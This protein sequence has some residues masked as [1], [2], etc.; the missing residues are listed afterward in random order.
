[1]SATIRPL[2]AVTI[3][4]PLGIGPEIVARALA[5]PQTYAVCRPV[6]IGQE[7]AL[8]RA[9]EVCGLE[10]R[11]RPVDDPRSVGNDFGTIDL[12]ESAQVGEPTAGSGE[13]QMRWAGECSYRFIATAVGWLKDGKADAT[14]SAPS[15]KEALGLAGH[16]FA[17]VTEIFAKLTAASKVITLLVVGPLRV[18]QITTHVAVR[19]AVEELTA[20]RILGA[21]EAAHRALLESDGAPPRLALAGLNPH[22]GENGLMGREELEV[23]APALAAARAQGIDVQG[24]IPAD[25]LFPRALRGEFNGALFPLHD[26]ANVGVKLLAERYP[27]V[28]VAVGLPVI[29]TTVAHGTAYDIAYRGVA[30]HRP[31]QAA[32]LLAAELARRKRADR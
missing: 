22:A 4:D 1:M 32:I 18:F 29:R 11:L 24:P 2:V 25:S 12:Y 7:A 20:E 28:T 23:F 6:V 26:Q 3:G 21:I 5:D 27:P 8:R 14:A 30:D 31:M 17:G 15:N 10:L 9:M 19:R 16:H 13:A